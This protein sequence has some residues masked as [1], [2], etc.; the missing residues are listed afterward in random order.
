[1]RVRARPTRLSRAR[2]RA[3][4]RARAD[5]P[6][7]TPARL[8]RVAIKKIRGTFKDL[9]DAKRILRE[10]KLLRHLGGHENLVFIRDVMTGRVSAPAPAPAPAAGAGVPAAPARSFEDVYIVTDLFDCDL[11]KIIES[12]QA[13]SDGHVKY[14][15]YQLLR[16]LKYLHSAGVLHRD[17]KPRALRA[18]DSH[19]LLRALT[20]SHA[21]LS[22]ARSPAPQRTCSS[23]PRASS[24]SPTWAWRAS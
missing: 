9:V 20:R 19:T 16:G 2:T 10:L 3:R 1:V 24:S 22:L 21:H 7:P 5:P 13:L 6:L 14:F 4:A 12:P 8:Q 17:L 11:Q 23:T 18:S 15:L